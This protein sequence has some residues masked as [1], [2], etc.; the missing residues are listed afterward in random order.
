MT[1]LPSRKPRS[2]FSDMLWETQR[3]SMAIIRIGGVE[4]LFI[5]IYGFA[6]RY[7]EGKRPNDLLLASLIPVVTEIGLPFCILGDFNEPP[8]K[9]PSFQFFRDM[10]AREAFEWYHAMSGILLPATCAGST[11]ND[12][13]ILHPWL[14]QHVHSMSVSSDVVFEPH[15]PLCIDL[16][17]N[18]DC[19]KHVRWNLPKSWASFAPDVNLIHDTYTPVDFE[20]IALKFPTDS[21]KQLDA[22]FATWSDAVENAV[23]KALYLAHCHDPVR[24]VTASLHSSYK[25]RCSFEKK[26]QK[27]QKPFVKS[28]RHGGY[29]PPSEV[30]TL[31]SRLKVRQVRRLRS[32]MRRLKSLEFLSPSLQSGHHGYISAMKEWKAILAAKGYGNKWSNWIL[33]FEAVGYLPTGLP[34]ADILELVTQITEHDCNCACIE[35]SR[36]RRDRFRATIQFDNE[37]DF[38]KLSYRIVRAK[39]TPVLSDV[40]VCRKTTARLLRSTIGATALQMDELIHIPK[41][42][43]V[44]FNDAKLEF[45]RQHERKVFFR[46]IEGRLESSGELCVTFHAVTDGEVLNEFERFWKPFWQRDRQEEQFESDAWQEFSNFLESGPLPKLP[47]IAMDLDDI[48]MWMKLIKKLPSNKAV[49]PCGWSNE[50]LKC[51][52]RCCV[53]DLI[54][55][56]SWVLKKG[57]TPSMMMAKTI[58][59][60]KKDVPL[61][62][63]DAR[64][65]TILSCLYRLFGKMIFKL[66]SRT[67]MGFFP[68]P[69][70]GGLPGRG[71]KEIAFVQKRQIEDA[72][73]LGLTRGGYSLDLVKAYNTFGRFAVACI[74]KHL[75]VPDIIVDAWILSLDR[76]VRY[77]T[78]NG[79]VGDAITSTTGV[80]EGCSISVIAM[81]GTSAFYYYNLYNQ[82]VQPFAYA[83]N[84]SWLTQ[85]QRAHLVAID[86][87][88]RVTHLLRLQIDHAKSWHWGTT[89]EFRKFCI[90]GIPPDGHEIIVKTM[91][92]DLGEIVHYNKSMSLG[93]VKEKIQD[94]IARVNRIENLPCSLQRKALMIQTS[95]FPMAFYSADTV[96]IGLHHFTAVRRAITHALVGNWHSASP[97]VAC[98]GLGKFM[99]DPFVFVLCHCARIIR[100]LANVDRAVALSTVQ[101]AVEFTGHRPFGPAGA[102]K[103]YLNQVGWELK[104]C[105]TILG[106]E[107]LSCN[108]LQD[109]TRKIRLIF[110]A[111]WEHHVIATMTRKGVGDF[112]IDFK[113]LSSVFS[114]RSECEQQLLKLNVVGGFQTQQQKALWDS[115]ITP[116]CQLCG[117][118]DTREHRFLLCGHLANVR[119]QHGEACR[120]LQCLRPEWCYLPLPRLFD[121]VTIIRAFVAT[122]KLPDL[123]APFETGSSHMR[124][125]TD[126]GAIHPSKHFSRLAAW[127]VIQDLSTSES[128]RRACVDFLFLQPPQLPL[129]RVAAMGLVAGEQ[130]VARGELQALVIACKIAIMS[131]QMKTVEF[132]TDASYVCIIVYIVESGMFSACLHKMPNADLILELNELWRPGNFC[133]TKVKSH[134]AFDEAKDI[135]DL[136]RIAGN[137]CADMVV[138]LAFQKVPSC[139]R[140][141]AEEAVQF[142][143]A[144]KAHL[145]C[146]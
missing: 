15:S 87:V 106:P 38:S 77:P 13:A 109:S 10:G 65:V 41:Y 108:I 103:C 17:I 39:K 110:M 35:E 63:H 101:F 131:P 130:T 86:M 45:L 44:M 118:P 113:L 56:F 136:W 73:Q 100:R 24:N 36:C 125:F 93:F 43:V 8:S 7:R 134:R 85:N 29:M 91:V 83:D 64:P 139:I 16:K 123:G 11:R 144:E 128:D 30:F 50:E 75:G 9:M 57:F 3:V 74:M 98:C 95:V 105:G 122:I 60:S 89:R 67:W 126:G 137:F 141:C 66:V 129:F 32:L 120:I 121:E 145:N 146:F 72:L 52:P 112:L 70:S 2:G 18:D 20:S 88:K 34:E 31:K 111:M 12:T 27:P 58:L 28:D 14:L 116:A 42:A 114:G 59:L 78:L 25:G 40:P 22:A 6:N 54:V 90:E 124:F 47:A 48:D 69:I 92:K 102:L 127:S 68:S 99:Q 135:E 80:P 53:N 115:D 33:A 46:H 104:A 81:L 82:H 55:I 4:I 96:Y 79:T 140:G 142:H 119:Q 61:S 76:M 132:F 84:W 143:K 23:D 5:S 62:M 71:V 26:F 1:C 107:L 97:F 94:A 21:C 133:V 117:E 138:N 37:F 19:E 49:G 51:L